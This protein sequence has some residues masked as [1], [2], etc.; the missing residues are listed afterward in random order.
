MIRMTKSIKLRSHE[1]WRWDGKAESLAPRQKRRKEFL[2][3]TLVFDKSPANT[4]LL[5]DLREQ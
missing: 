5:A 1:S 3:G 2:Q 4:D